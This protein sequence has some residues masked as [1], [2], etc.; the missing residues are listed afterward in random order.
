MTFLR[1]TVYVTGETSKVTSPH[2][3]CVGPWKNSDVSGN[4]NA[5]FDHVNIAYVCT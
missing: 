4:L 3:T 2:I 1:K 5:I